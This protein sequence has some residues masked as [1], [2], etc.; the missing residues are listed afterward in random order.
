MKSISSVI[1]STRRRSLKA[2]TAMLA[3]GAAL[4]VSG[5]AFAQAAN[6][7]GGQVGTMAQ[8]ATTAGGNIGS[9]AMYLAALLCLIAGAWSLWQSRQPQNR[10]GGKVAMGLAGI[11][12]CGLFATGG[13]WIG[14]AAQTASGGAAT[15]T[16]TNAPVTFGN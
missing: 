5:K 16:G 14:K 4:L 3:A 1:V 10:E 2:G 9:M 11:V 12:L 15:I 8:E 6:G 7:I 13:V